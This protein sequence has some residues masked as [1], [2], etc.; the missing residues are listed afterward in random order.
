M[1]R[2]LDWSSG[3]VLA[4]EASGTM[5]KQD[6]QQVL[7]EVSE[8][9]E[10]YGKVR[11]YVRLPE[12]AWPEFNAVWDRIKFAKEYL[13]GIERY[14]LVSDI[15]ALEWVSKIAGMF[16]G[17]EFRQFSLKDEEIARWW[18]EQKK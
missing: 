9:I 3:K 2:K 4:Y 13:G 17:I 6:H 1:I 12:M 14:A 15:G 7:G 5:T 18:L 16:T 8:A 11:L 10:T